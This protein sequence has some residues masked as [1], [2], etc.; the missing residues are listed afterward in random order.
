MLN[1]LNLVHL[2]HWA[3]EGRTCSRAKGLSRFHESE[4]SE[5]YRVYKPVIDLRRLCSPD[6]LPSF[7]RTL[8]VPKSCEI[9]RLRY[10][11]LEYTSILQSTE[12]WVKWSTSSNNAGGSEQSLSRRMRL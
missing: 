4:E 6:N 8:T 2:V 5:I 3:P 11:S 1:K 9:P 7:E 10:S 12:I